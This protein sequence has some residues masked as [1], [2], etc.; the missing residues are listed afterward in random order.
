MA[1]LV[2]GSV[3]GGDR[4]MPQH[5]SLPTRYIHSLLAIFCMKMCVMLMSY[6]FH[7][8]SKYEDWG[9]THPLMWMNYIENVTVVERMILANHLSTTS[10]QQI[11]CLSDI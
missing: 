11:V 4:I 1:P 7:W 3:L 2:Y 5:I 10:R 8:R 6:A 9:S